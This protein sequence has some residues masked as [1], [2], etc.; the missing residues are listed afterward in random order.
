MGADDRI[1]ILD[2]VA[3]LVRSCGRCELCR[4]RTHAVPGHGNIQ[5][6]IMFIGEAPGQHEDRQG[7]P[8][9]GA[10]GQFLNHLLSTIELSR[11]DVFITNIVKCRPPGNRDPLPDEIAACGSYLDTQID[12]IDPLM[13][14]TL[15]RFSMSK[16][17][18]NERISR[19]HGQPR[20]FGKR[21]VV[22]MYHPAAALHQASLRSTIEADFERLPRILAQAREQL[23]P[24]EEQP[25]Q[26]AQ[27]RLF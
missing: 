20:T 22:P 9:I 27:M 11:D 7:L 10:S 15:G 19:I 6:E 1:R 21:V 17:F 13:I 24:A 16:W 14:V 3:T 5:T 12:A 23:A 25:D 4:G 8:F 26:A 2:E 18:P